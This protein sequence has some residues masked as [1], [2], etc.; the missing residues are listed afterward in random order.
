[1]LGL[2]LIDLAVRGSQVR[3]DLHQDWK[4]E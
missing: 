4:E 1:V 3:Y 2:E